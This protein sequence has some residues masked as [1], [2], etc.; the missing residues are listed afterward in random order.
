M[1]SV[2][3]V[4]RIRQFIHDTISELHKC[5]WPRKNELFESTLLVL[6]ATAILSAFV[7][8]VDLIITLLIGFVTK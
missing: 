6:V 1:S 4:G 2:S 3:I 8:V 7:A 5:T